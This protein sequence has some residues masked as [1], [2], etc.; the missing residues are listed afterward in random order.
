[1]PN[2]RHQPPRIGAVGF[3]LWLERR[4]GFVIGSQ[5]SHDVQ[6]HHPCHTTA[7]VPMLESQELPSKQYSKRDGRT[8][9]RDSP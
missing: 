1:M 9:Q 4:T 6:F 2:V 8:W 5:C 7:P 3:M